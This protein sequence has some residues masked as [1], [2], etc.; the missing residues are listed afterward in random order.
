MSAIPPPAGDTAA[1]ST[2][3]DSTATSPPPFDPWA[4]QVRRQALHHAQR[5]RRRRRQ[6]A[7]LIVLAVL[8][9]GVAAASVVI[10]RRSDDRSDDASTPADVASSAVDAVVPAA[11]GSSAP[12]PTSAPDELVEVDEVWLVD[13]GDS[14]FDWGVS[15][16]TPPS[17]PRR[18]GVVIDVWLTDADGAVVHTASGEVDGI[19]PESTGAVAGRL[20]A[21]V[22]DPVRIEFD[23]AVGVESNDRGIGEVLSVRALERTPDGVSGR[24]ATTT[25]EPIEDFT[26]VLLWFDEAGEVVAAV[27]QRVDRV[28][29]GVE[30]RFDIDL[31]TEPVPD[32]DPDSVV[33]TR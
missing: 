3:P 24:I 14:T 16:R 26:M 23:V 30:A 13:R 9:A 25:T 15:V 29:P 4:E 22:S 31:S 28:R 8:V 33:W 32:G 27:P 12:A 11:P 1:T 18:S 10:D 2:V 21:P 5:R 17:A 6:A 20:T 19:G 7:P